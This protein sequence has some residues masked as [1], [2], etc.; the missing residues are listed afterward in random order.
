MQEQF[1]YTAGLAKANGVVNGATW[2]FIALGTGYRRCIE[3]APN[4]GQATVVLQCKHPVSSHYVGDYALFDMTYN[5]DRADSALLGAL[6]N[7]PHVRNTFQT[8]LRHLASREHVSI[9]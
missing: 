2:P 4:A 8:T 7:D 1:A 3:S 6:I 5:Y 9:I